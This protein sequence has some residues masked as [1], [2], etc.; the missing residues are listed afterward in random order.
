MNLYS[1]LVPKVALSSS[2]LFRLH[3]YVRLSDYKVKSKTLESFN[4]EGYNFQKILFKGVT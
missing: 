3:M 4:K 1:C 2:Q